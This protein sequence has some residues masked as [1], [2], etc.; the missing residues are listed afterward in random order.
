MVFQTICRST[1]EKQRELRELASSVDALI[2]VGG[3]GSAN[4]RRL[5][6]IARS[7][8]V[9]TFH[10]ESE[11]D[12]DDAEISVFD[13]I[14]I[15]SGSST[16]NW[17]IFRIMDR[18]EE[19]GRKSPFAR[20]LR[21]VIRFAVKSNLYAAMGAGF[22]AYSASMIMSIQPSMVHIIGS[23]MYVLSMHILNHFTDREA[24]RFSE[25][26]MMRFCEQKR[27]LLV[28]MGVAGVCIVLAV[29]VVQGLLPFIFLSVA[30]LLGVAYSISIIPI[31]KG[32][33]VSLVRIRDIPASKDLFV[34]A[35]WTAVIVL[36][37]AIGGEVAFGLSVFVAAAYVFGIV[38]IRCLLFSMS[39][40]QEDMIVGRETIPTLLGKERSRVISIVATLVLGLVLLGAIPLIGS[41]SLFLM[42]PPGYILGC[43][44]LY[45]YRVRQIS[46]GTL[47]EVVLDTSFV[48]AGVSAIFW[49]ARLFSEAI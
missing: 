2:V 43:I 26:T 21:E 25:P 31:W 19:I 30:C 49:K 6:D 45:Y 33:R 29:G 42:F 32:G 1:R 13:K 14:G 10:V 8:G 48:L 36:L 17:M 12:I 16:P 22:L 15:V 4:T 34:P 37:P 28:P 47:F 40:V 3:R 20:W 46:H 5:A 27:F 11:S 41:L 24:L 7:C 9:R 35:A 39:D 23:A 18:L 44:Y 38:F